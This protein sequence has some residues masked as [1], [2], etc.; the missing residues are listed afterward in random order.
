MDLPLAPIAFAANT[1][2]SGIA[3]YTDWKTGYIFDWITYPLIGL[4]IILSILNG[5]WIGIAL[6]IGIYA[7]G[8][9][10]Y[11]QG[12]LGGGDIK[13]LAGM[14]VVQPIYQGQLFVLSVL[15]VACIVACV[16]LCIQ[17]VG[18]YLLSK[19]KINW[20]EPRKRLG[21]GMVIA[22][23]VFLAYSFDQGIFSPIQAIV[24][25]LAVGM[26][27]LF[28][29]LEDEIKVHAFLKRI[30]LEQ[31]EDDELLAAE[32]LSHEE[33][34]KLGKDIPAL[35]DRG[36]IARFRH[37]GMHT[38]PVYRDLPKFA[39]FL[40]AGVLVVYVFPGV[41]SAFIPVIA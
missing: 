40:F 38:I 4:G 8:Y 27:I 1:I 11:K 18:S 36:D 6:G 33:K 13:L 16:G 5:Q 39:P 19:P 32:H 2:A 20:K 15:L 37:A 22:L 14:A 41:L 31:V 17:Y 25:L 34:Q 29:M 28:Y 12:K 23:I 26:G 3:A 10:A 21:F 7:I 35:I 30:P 24:L 9:F